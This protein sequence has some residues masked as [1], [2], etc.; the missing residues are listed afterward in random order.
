MQLYRYKIYND[1]VKSKTVVI[2]RRKAIGSYISRDSQLPELLGSWVFYKMNKTRKVKKST[3]IYAATCM[4]L[5]SL[6]AVFTATIAWFALNEDVEGNGMGIEIKTN[7]DSFTSLKIYRCITEESTRNLLKFSSSP[8]VYTTYEDRSDELGEGHEHDLVYHFEG[9]HTGNYLKLDDWGDLSGSQPILFLFELPEDTALADIYMTASTAV[10]RLYTIS[11]LA[12]DT[13]VNSFPLSQF[14][15]FN[16]ATY[17]DGAYNPNATETISEGGQ[18]TISATLTN[19]PIKPESVIIET[20][21]G[22]SFSDDGNGVIAGDGLTSGTINYETGAIAL[23][24]TTNPS[25][26][27]TASYKI[28]GVTPSF[29]FNQVVVS[30]TI[31]SECNTNQD[32]IHMNNPNAFV[33][34]E[35]DEWKLTDSSTINLYS[36]ND[37][38]HTAHYLAVVVDYYFD[39]VSDFQKEFVSGIPEAVEENANRIGF[40]CDWHLTF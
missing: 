9:E 21:D 34:K 30:S 26:A 15:I 14:T 22:L 11:D 7:G 3:K 17:F 35:N 40:V 33:I 20:A 38:T 36:S 32:Y 4:T 31:P 23:T 2:L 29:P 5:F 13:Y 16:S 28:D 19:T 8:A 27:V 18:A 6:V 10:K 25:G 12:D 39:R 1:K 37:E 24:F